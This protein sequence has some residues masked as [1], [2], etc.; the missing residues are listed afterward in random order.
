MTYY[1]HHC[2]IQH[3]FP[4]QGSPC[5]GQ[6]P[7]CITMKHATCITRNH[8]P[9]P[10]RCPEP[11][12]VKCDAPST[13]LCAPK[14]PAPVDAKCTEPCE[15]KCAEKCASPC[16][17]PCHETSKAKHFPPQHV[18]RFNLSC[19]P[20]PVKPYLSRG[21]PPCGP[22]LEV[23]QGFPA[24]SH[25]FPPRKTYQYTASKTFKSCYAK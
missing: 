14:S 4:V 23:P 5:A 7:H 25:C 19:P 9:F 10:T 22:K 24:T 20:R 13:E 17:T 3:S 21:H 11:C 16:T 15:S 1:S 12:G 18:E 6:G 2:R 8:P